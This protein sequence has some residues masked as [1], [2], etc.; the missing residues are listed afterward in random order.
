MG[1]T[2]VVL[3]EHAL[4]VRPYE[5]SPCEHTSSYSR[6]CD[7]RVLLLLTLCMFGL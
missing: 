7:L 5:V 1:L 4:D 2:L 3:A 6:V